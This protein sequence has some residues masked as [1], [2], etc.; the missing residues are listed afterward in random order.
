[1]NAIQEM[2]EPLFSVGERVQ[3]LGANPLEGLIQARKWTWAQFG[4]RYTVLIPSGQQIG[5]G[6]EALALVETHAPPAFDALRSR[7]FVQVGTGRTLQRGKRSSQGV[8]R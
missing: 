8:A 5:V 2:T 3:M 6:E 1:L 7:G 4:W